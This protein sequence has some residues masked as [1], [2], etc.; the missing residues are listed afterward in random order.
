MDVA[1]IKIVLTAYTALLLLVSTAVVAMLVGARVSSQYREIGLLKAIGL[2]PGQV[3]FVLVLEAATLGLAG[4]LLGFLPAM[5]LAPRLA[6][7]TAETLVAAP[8]VNA[9]ASQML[10]A[11]LVVLPVVATSAFLAARRSTRS[12]V[13]QALRSG[14]AAPAARSPLARLINASGLPIP[15]RLGLLD[16]LARRM[17]VVWLMWTIGATS[18]ALVVTLSI[19]AALA[20]RP[21]GEPSDVPAELP[22]LILALDAVMAVIALS[23]LGSVALLAVRERVRDF[24]VLRTV[25][26][27]P[28]QVTLSLAGA[29]VAVAFVSAC[30]AVPA[31][32]ALYLVL[33][34]AASG[35][36]PDTGLA[37]WSSI[38]AVPF[39]I[40]IATAIATG[41][42]AR[43]VARIPPA[44][45]VRFE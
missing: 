10:I 4:V 22:A 7:T 30:L 8:V 28:G 2:T 31:G 12:S 6:A 43:L 35:E 27:T 41:L 45:A 19:S 3:S 26:L 42:P 25:G 24:G 17:R 11:A 37:P 18:A 33:Y 36:S 38:A 1:P 20:D 21:A 44:E 5:L 16:M 13:L 9:D 32:I 29:H 34:A 40:S 23:A 15:I 14:A 39:A